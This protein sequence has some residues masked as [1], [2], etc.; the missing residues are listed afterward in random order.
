M[1]ASKVTDFALWCLLLAGA[2]WAAYSG[3]WLI[4]LARTFP[5][6]SARTGWSAMLA[7]AQGYGVVFGPMA[8]I[9]ALLALRILIRRRELTR[10]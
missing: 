1:A 6:A 3:Y 10:G 7:D 8:L 2:G 5:A 4:W 9:V